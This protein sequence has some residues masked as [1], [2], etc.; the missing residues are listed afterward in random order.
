MTMDLYCHVENSTLR[1]EMALM[2]DVV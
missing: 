1:E 2:G